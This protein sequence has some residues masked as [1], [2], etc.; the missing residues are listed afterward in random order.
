VLSGD[1]GRAEALLAKLRPGEAYG[2]PRA[3]AV[4]HILCGAVEKAADWTEKAIEQRDP[5][6]ML[7]L[8]YPIAKALRSSARWP[9]LAKMMNLPE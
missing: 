7:F 1:T 6:M 4:F 9:A 5:L 3:F 8:R 2:A